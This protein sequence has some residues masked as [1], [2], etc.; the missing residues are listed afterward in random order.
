MVWHTSLY[1]YTCMYSPSHWF[2]CH[3]TLVMSKS[4]VVTCLPPVLSH[5][6]TAVYYVV[7]HNMIVHFLLMKGTSCLLNDVSCGAVYTL[8]HCFCIV[9]FSNAQMLCCHTCIYVVRTHHDRHTCKCM[10][11]CLEHSLVVFMVSLCL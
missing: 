3:N 9:H 2:A 1:N 8:R 7:Q 4:C 10:C 6:T 5:C 11:D